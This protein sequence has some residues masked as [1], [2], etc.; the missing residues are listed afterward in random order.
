MLEW[1]PMLTYNRLRAY[2]RAIRLIG[3]GERIWGFVDGT[4]VGF[5]RPS[6]HLR[7]Q[8][9][10]NGKEKEH[11]QKFQAIVAADGLVVS[12]YGLWIGP[13]NDWK[14]WKVSRLDQRL[15]QVIDRQQMLFVYG[16]PA[17]KAS[18]RVMALYTYK[19]NWRL[20]LR[21]Q[22]AFNKRLLHV[23]IAVEHA[24]GHTQVLWTYTAFAKQLKSD[25]QPVAAFFAV[26]VLLTNCYTCLQGN[27][28]SCKFLVQPPSLE[29]YL[30][31]KFCLFTLFLYTPLLIAASV[32]FVED[33][34]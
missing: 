25:L 23:C 10:Y 11:G 4:F 33:L 16:D 14:M 6:D 26:A 20:L 31:S 9:C 18:Y 34:K 3:G 1:H 13:V 8:A 15:W 17:Y 7:Q 21:D 27:Q 5:C 2:E 30:N 29:D 24:F 22:R 32:G 12:F 28:T 19:V